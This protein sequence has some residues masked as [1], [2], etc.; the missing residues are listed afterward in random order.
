MQ[1][2]ST[3]Y[4]NERYYM[5]SLIQWYRKVWK[6]DKFIFFIGRPQITKSNY[7]RDGV[8]FSSQRREMLQPTNTPI[9]LIIGISE[10]QSFVTL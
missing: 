9:C 10:N 5:D 6:A 7:H 3:F 1:I 4:N 8:D 2:A